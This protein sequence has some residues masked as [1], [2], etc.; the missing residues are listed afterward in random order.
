[1]SSRIQLI[2]GL[3]NPGAKYEPTRHNAGFWFV[4]A[5][6]RQH[7]ATFKS[8]NKFHGEACKLLLDREE[9]WLLK[10]MTFMNKSGQAI[11]ALANFY[12]ITPEA[13]LVAH[14]ELDLPPGEA[15][16]KKGGGHGGHNGLRDTIAQLGNNKDFQRLRIGIG[17]PGHSSQVT[18]YVLGKA[19]ADEQRL[20]EQAIDNALDVM[21]LAVCGEMQKAMNQLHSKN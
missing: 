18:G 7:G 2:V 8:E 3:G 4:D 6:A 13:I 16:L 15:R 9:I 12:K 11:A 21:P 19:P 1:M 17:H 5:L 14:D 10:P 20:M